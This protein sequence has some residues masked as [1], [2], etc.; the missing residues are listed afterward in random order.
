MQMTQTCNSGVKWIALGIDQTNE[1]QID[2]DGNDDQ[3]HL[4]EQSTIKPNTPIIILLIGLRLQTSE[5]WKINVKRSKTK[6]FLNKFD[7]F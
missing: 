7:R 2:S 5:D 3:P 6:Q 1:S 4:I